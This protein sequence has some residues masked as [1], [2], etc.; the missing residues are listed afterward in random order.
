M[1][2][3][4]IPLLLSVLFLSSCAHRF[5]VFDIHSEEVISEAGDYFLYENDELEIYY[6]YWTEGG[7]PVFKIHN[8]TADTLFLDLAKSAFKVNGVSIDYYNPTYKGQ[9]YEILRPIP[10]PPVVYV[11]PYKSYQLEGFPISWR[12]ERIKNDPGYV[13]F[14][15]RDSPIRFTNKIAYFQRLT[16]D[17][18][19]VENEFWVGRIKK[20][21]RKDFEEFKKRKNIKSNKFYV[22]RPDDGNDVIWGDAIQAVLEILLLF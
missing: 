4:Y 21:K 1:K 18:R 10:L 3:V 16:P 12:W 7:I 8:R 14:T 9:Q 20:Y 13:R 15:E 5:Q 22:Y 11:L 17:R 2:K 6:D 19:V